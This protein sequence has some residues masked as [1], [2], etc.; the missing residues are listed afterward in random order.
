MRKSI[1]DLL[2]RLLIFAII[3]I[4]AAVIGVILFDDNEEASLFA[5]SVVSGILLIWM[6]VAMKKNIS[7]YRKTNQFFGT[8][9]DTATIGLIAY[10]MSRVA[11]SYIFLYFILMEIDI[12]IGDNSIAVT[13]LGLS[14]FIGFIS[15]LIGISFFSRRASGKS[16]ENNGMSVEQFKARYGDGMG[17]YS[18]LN[19]DRLFGTDE[20]SLQFASLLAG[21]R[22]AVLNDHNEPPLA[23]AISSSYVLP[24][25]EIFPRDMDQLYRQSVQFFVIPLNNLLYKHGY[26]LAIQPEQWQGALK[27]FATAQVMNRLRDGINVNFFLAH[28]AERILEP[29]G[30]AVVELICSQGGRYFGVVPFQSLQYFQQLSM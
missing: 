29:Q 22:E 15:I 25:P 9:N 18:S 4:S 16:I 12:D 20:R 8:R 19:V 7:E 10:V 3:S 23:V 14:V 30:I 6:L 17:R 1:K 5:I 27:G 24:M 11:W 2:I 21:D 26:P 28:C 13:A